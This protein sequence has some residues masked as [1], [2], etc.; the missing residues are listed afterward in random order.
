MKQHGQELQGEHDAEHQGERDGDGLDLLP[1][2]AARLAV[3]GD[4]HG[5]VGGVLRDDLQAA[6]EHDEES[7]DEQE[8]QA[9]LVAQLPQLLL[10]RLLVL[11]VLVQREQVLADELDPEAP[12]CGAGNDGE[13][14]RIVVMVVVVVVIMM[15]RRMVMV[16]MMMVMM[17]MMMMVVV[18]VVV[19][20]VVAM[21]TM[22]TTMMVMMM[23]MMRRRRRRIA[24]RIVVVVVVVVVVVMMMIM[25]MMTMMMMI[26]IINNN[27]L[28]VVIPT[29]TTAA[30]TLRTN[31]SSDCYTAAVAAADDA[32]F[33][34]GWREGVLSPTLMNKNQQMSPNN[35]DVEQPRR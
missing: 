28:I 15:R 20:V 5:Q 14:R 25:M 35:L 16:M 6:D 26:L 13:L 1:S 7:V 10:H 29:T 3:A 8:G 12:L 4:L 21:M 19:V 18:V 24:R 33:P 27:I 2:E 30:N 11:L 17:V 31:L 34:E 9:D 32:D 22:M 23:M